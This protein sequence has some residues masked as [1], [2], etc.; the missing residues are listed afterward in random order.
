MIQAIPT[1]ATNRLRAPVRGRARAGWRGAAALCWPATWV[2]GRV[3]GGVD[4]ACAGRLPGEAASV[5]G[6]GAGAAGDGPGGALGA[7]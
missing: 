3:G 4:A 6:P 7:G 5:A 1:M 2:A